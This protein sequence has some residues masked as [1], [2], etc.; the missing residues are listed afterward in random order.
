MHEMRLDCGFKVAE[1]AEIKVRK[2]PELIG[3]GKSARCAN[4]SL[5]LALSPELQSHFFANIY[6]DNISEGG[7]KNFVQRRFA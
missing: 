3:I 1:S 7:C 6:G 4:L 2:T 5:S